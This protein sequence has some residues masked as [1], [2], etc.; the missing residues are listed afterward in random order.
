M[1]LNVLD[2]KGVFDPFEEE[3]GLDAAGGGGRCLFGD[4]GHAT[5]SWGDGGGCFEIG[6]ISD[7]RGAVFFGDGHDMVRVGVFM[8]GMLL[9]CNV[10]LY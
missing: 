5:E 7:G 3:G 4:G 9:L 6:A 8:A 2:A 10:V 1:R